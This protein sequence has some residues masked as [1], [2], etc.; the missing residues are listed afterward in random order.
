VRGVVQLGEDV[1]T[2]DDG[3]R[4]LTGTAEQIRDDLGELHGAGV[5]EVFLDL[6]FTPRVGSPDVDP[7]GS[8]AHAHE[9]LET[10]A[11]R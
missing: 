3:R 11:P 9:V 7:V 1:R 2:E 6:N 8:E 10:F 5:T 4:T